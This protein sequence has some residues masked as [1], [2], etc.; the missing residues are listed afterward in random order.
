[1]FKDIVAMKLPKIGMRSIKTFIAV[2]L[3]IIISNILGFESPFY[4]TLTVFFCMQTSIIESSEVAVQRSL[5]TLIGGIVSLIYLLLVPGNMYMIPFG[6]L[7]IIYL[8]NLIDKRD[9]IP[10]AGVVFLVLSFG[11]DPGKSFDIVAY[12]IDRV[13]ATCVGI[14]IAIVV[15]YY[16]KPPNP[17]KKLNELNVEMIE[18]IQKN[19]NEEED[20][21]KVKNLEEYRIKIHEFRNIIEFYHKEI[22]SKRHNVDIKHYMRHLSLFKTAYSHMFILNARKADMSIDIQKYHIE[23]LRNIKEELGKVS[24]DK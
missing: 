22:N 17:F 8:F 10:I 2:L 24:P 19:V 7:G 1:M 21:R 5:G 9:M 3:A 11:V 23:N 16:I 18:F 20:F 4:V 13:L 12:V 6:V 15:N 14:V